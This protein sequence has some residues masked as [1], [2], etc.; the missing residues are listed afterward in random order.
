[1]YYELFKILSIEVN[2]IPIKALMNYKGL[3]VGLYRLPLDIIDENN[4]KALIYVYEGTQRNR[5]H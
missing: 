2:P 5:Y 4:L 3:N 1:M